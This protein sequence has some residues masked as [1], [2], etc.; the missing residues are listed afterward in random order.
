MAVV[1]SLKKMG[2]VDFASVS[3]NGNQYITNG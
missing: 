3:I 1:S 2:A